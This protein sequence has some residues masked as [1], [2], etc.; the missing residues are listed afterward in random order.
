MWCSALRGILILTLSL[1][2][3]PLAAEAQ[4]RGHIPIVGVLSPATSEALA[5]PERGLYAF[6]QGVRE[7]GY[8]EGQTIR[9]EYRFADWQLDRLPAL[10]AELVQLN[11][12]I[13]FTYT[14]P[15][16]L[17][18]K[19]ATTTIPIVVIT[20]GL[21]DQG[22][23]A[24][25]DRPGGNITG[26]TT[27]GAEMYGKQLELLKEAAPHI[28]RVA[29]MVNAA[30]PGSD[31]YPAILAAEARALGVQLHRLEVR[32]PG[33]FDGAFAALAEGRADALLVLSDPLFGTHRQRLVALVAMHRL[34]SI[35]RMAGFAEAGGLMQYG[36]DIPGMYRRTATYV[37]KILQ[38]AKP[39]ELPIERATKF[40]LVIN[41]KTAKALGITIPP[42]LLFRA[43]EVIQ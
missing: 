9:L 38:G 26:T 42:T 10:A 34:P 41:L 2:A 20:D 23:V 17:A 3:V 1:L 33:E 29:V 31:R 40:A 16:V 5:D 25:L 28:A 32:G 36:E 7:L 21:V 35:A 8:I 13:I 19:Q 14:A 24:S 18:A 15:G 39:G 37:H 4:P 27:F 43:D 6:V 30:N 11:P 22:I 12:D